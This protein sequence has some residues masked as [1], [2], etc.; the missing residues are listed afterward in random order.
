MDGTCSRDRVGWAG[1]A[2]RTVMRTPSL[3]SVTVEYDAA[4]P[5]RGTMVC[6]F[7][8]ERRTWLGRALLDVCQVR[9]LDDPDSAAVSSYG[10]F[11]RQQYRQLA[12]IK[13]SPFPPRPLDLSGLA[14]EPDEARS[15][16]RDHARH[17]SPDATV[18]PRCP[19]LVLTIHQGIVAWQGTVD[20]DGV[21]IHTVILDGASGA[22]LFHKFDRHHRA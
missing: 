8:Q 2:A 7:Q 20:F 4:A 3:Y 5:E 9:V 14:I 17:E 21:G 11:G 18:E 19:G 6:G 13:E 1:R 12:A 15:R 10:T 16:M 22:V